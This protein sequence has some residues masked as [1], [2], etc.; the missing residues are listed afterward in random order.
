MAVV[1]Y[2]PERVSSRTSSFSSGAA[3][4][5]DCYFLLLDSIQVE[6]AGQVHLPGS[7]QVRFLKESTLQPAVFLNSLG[8]ML[9]SLTAL[10]V[11]LLCNSVFTLAVAVF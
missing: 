4:G 1:G 3:G 11:K 6:V 5:G 10:V 9:N 2:N 7:Y 8:R